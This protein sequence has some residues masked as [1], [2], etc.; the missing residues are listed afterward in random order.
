MTDPEAMHIIDYDHTRSPITRAA[1]HY[2][3]R[4]Q[5]ARGTI[6]AM[7]AII[8]ALQGELKGRIKK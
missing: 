3:R 8:E 6:Q 1:R 4:F 5:D 7:K 2:L